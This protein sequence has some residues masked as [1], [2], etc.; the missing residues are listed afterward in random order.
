MRRIRWI[1]VI[2]GAVMTV[3][4]SGVLLALSG[5][6][7]TPYLSA[8]TDSAAIDGAT[9]ATVADERVYGLLMGLSLLSAILLAFFVGGFVVGRLVP[10]SGGLNGT[11]MGLIVVLAGLVFLL[12]NLVTV[13]GPVG[14]PGEFYSQS[15]NLRMLVVALAAYVV[16]SPIVI[17]A[18]FWGGRIGRRLGGGEPVLDGNN[19]RNA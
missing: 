14:N 9:S 11:V 17:L 2:L 3:A 19:R 8:I 13:L 4:L 15:E 18:G 7:L 10:L 5:L 12:G 6:L 16:V 1:S